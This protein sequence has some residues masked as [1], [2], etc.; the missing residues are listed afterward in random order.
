M[1][2]LRLK[3]K[4]GGFPLS[5][6]CGW[7]IREFL[8]GN[9]LHGSQVIYPEVGTPHAEIF[10]HYKNA[11]HQETAMGRATRAEEKRA[12][13]EKRSI[14]RDQI[15]QLYQ[16]YLSRISYKANGCRYHSFITYFSNLQRLGGVKPTGQEEPFAFPE[17]YAAGQS[18]RYYRLTKAGLKAGAGALLNLHLTLY[19]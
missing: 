17:N 8:L 7:F 18:R 11:L 1:T 16:T 12:R 4:R 14:D 19:G 9:G 3:P 10:Y 15:E 5:F 13:R 2:T 6:D